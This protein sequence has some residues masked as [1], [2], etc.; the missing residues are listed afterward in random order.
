MNTNEFV[1]IGVHSWLIHLRITTLGVR[2]CRASLAISPQSVAADEG[3]QR[4]RGTQLFFLEEQ[5]IAEASQT[6]IS[7]RH[8][9]PDAKLAVHI[10]IERPRSSRD[11]CDS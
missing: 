9:S 6:V 11:R 10:L 8:R 2:L 5:R 1:F 3:A 4:F 7:R